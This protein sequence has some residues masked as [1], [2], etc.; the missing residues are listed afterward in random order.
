MMIAEVASFYD[1]VI[2]GGGPSGLIAAC[3]AADRGLRTLVVDRGEKA[4]KKL[5]ITGKGRCNL[6]NDCDVETFLSNIRRGA[7]FLRSCV[8]GFSS[9]EVM[10][11]FEYRGLALVTERGS[12][13]FPESHDANDVAETLIGAVRDAG[14][15]IVR[16]RVAEVVRNSGAVSAVILQ[17][18]VKIACKAVIIAT[19]GLS[20][21]KTGSTG[22][23]YVMAKKMSH[24]INPP[25]ASLVP[26]VCET[27]EFWPTGLSLK[28]VE[29]TARRAKTRVFHERGELLFTHFGLSGPLT[30]SM[31]SHLVGEEYREIS[32]YIDLKPALEPEKLDA[33]I[34]R[35]FSENLNKELKN[36]LGAL[37]PKSII[38]A[39]I[40]KSGID[41]GKRINSVTAAERAAL[42]GA[43]KRFT[44]SVIE[45][46]PIEEA[47]ITAGGVELSEIDPKTMMSKKVKNLHFAGEVLDADG[48]TGGFNLG[49][50]FATGA[51]AGSQVLEGMKFEV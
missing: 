16:G 46:R 33:R 13:V 7:K 23:G 42:A 4:G 50:A 11:F 27:G 19:G 2:A 26:L 47:V 14:A 32:A 34:I 6:T 3:Y 24:T 36:S 41:P 5:R 22:D 25:R 44:V 17:P 15:E 30:L 12:R 18:G 1:V 38:P 31:S 40:S 49:I 51:A 8:T 20:Y 43:I 10:R 39:V 21:P 29:L 9:A 45:P 37:L 48:Y 35:D 28:N